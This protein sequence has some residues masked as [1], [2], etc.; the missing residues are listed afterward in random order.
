VAIYPTNELWNL[1]PSDP[2]YNSKT[3]RDRIPTQKRLQQAEPILAQ[4][5]QV[6]MQH[7][8]LNTALH[9]DVRLRFSSTPP[10]KSCFSRWVAN[11]V[12]NFVDQ[13]GTYRNLARF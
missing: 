10:D 6:Y 13:V 7:K 1:V 2:D 9:E 8:E 4:T 11:S 5:Y 12:V 3:K